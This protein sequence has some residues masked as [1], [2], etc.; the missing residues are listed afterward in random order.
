[1]TNEIYYKQ[2]KILSFDKSPNPSHFSDLAQLV[3]TYRSEGYNGIS[4]ADRS[5]DVWGTDP[6]FRQN[7]IS[8][9]SFLPHLYPIKYFWLGTINA[10]LDQIQKLYKLDLEDLHLSFISKYFSQ[11][12]KKI[13]KDL[14]FVRHY[15]NLK[16]LSLAAEPSSP[17]SINGVI[18]AKLLYLSI[19][20]E[21][22]SNV[23][24]K[25]FPSLEALITG[26][27]TRSADSF[28]F[29]ALSKLRALTLTG[30]PEASTFN[31]LKDLKD[32]EILNL[33]CRSLVDF[34]DLSGLKKLKWVSLSGCKNLRSY[35]NLAKAPNLHQVV[36]NGSLGKDYNLDLFRPLAEHPKLK[37]FSYVY[38]YQLK[39]EIRNIETMF[40]GKAQKSYQIFL[41]EDGT[42][43][44][45]QNTEL[46]EM[47]NSG[48]L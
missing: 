14:S 35:E 30:F 24:F 36:I 6:D 2:Y 5:V 32:L 46:T 4:F 23:D 31:F 17:I 28:S 37:E 34:P 22:I 25:C 48:K 9:L 43:W 1:M 12:K 19:R 26:S 38:D 3:E 27:A 8:D 29:G 7:H 33:G 18:F 40:Q 44:S 10:N 15:E 41:I 47:L 39:R 45:P 42:Y 16:R 20:Y 11:I 21:N 13:I